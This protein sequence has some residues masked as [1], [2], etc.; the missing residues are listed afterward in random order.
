M[1]GPYVTM[2]FYSGTFVSP[3]QSGATEHSVVVGVKRHMEESHVDDE[4]PGSSQ[5]A[6]EQLEEGVKKARIDE[7]SPGEQ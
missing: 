1:M 7:S 6:A 5:G 2:C 3:G 4:S